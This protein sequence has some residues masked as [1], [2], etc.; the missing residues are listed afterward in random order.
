MLRPQPK[1]IYWIEL[2]MIG[3]DDRPI[4][5][6]EYEV[7]LPDGTKVSGYLNDQGLAR[8]DNIK[9]AGTCGVCFPD[10]DQDAWVT[11]S[12]MQEGSSGAV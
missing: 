1:P 7:T 5:W 8:I 10:L 3:E 6:E 9:S 11:T 12:G 4:P 2:E